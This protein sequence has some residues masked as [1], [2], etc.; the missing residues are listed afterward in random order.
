MRPLIGITA[1]MD[2]EV[3]LLKRNYCDAVERAGGLPLILP[4]LRESPRQL[5]AAL[6]GLVIPGGDDLPP[7]YYGEPLAVPPGC[8]TPAKRERCDFEIALL[9]EMTER[10]KPVLGICYGMQLINVAFGGTLYQDIALQ[11]PGACLHKKTVHPVT[12][13][14]SFG[15]WKAGER[16]T[17]NSYHH[18][19]VKRLG[20]GLEALAHSG[21]GL[22]EG[23]YLKDYPFLLAVQWHPERSSEG[24]PP[25]SAGE[26]PSPGAPLLSP[27]SC[28]KLVVAIFDLFIQASRLKS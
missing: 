13:A 27:G 12:M 15:H 28:D 23:F 17:V 10:R 22:I 20:R 3:F 8:L 18:Q 14:A 1:D 9:R 6:D 19:A 5:A 7:D 2:D 24:L 16:F 4:P 21:D 25:A 11:A 26:P